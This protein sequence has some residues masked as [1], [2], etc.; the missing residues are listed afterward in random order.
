MPEGA[1]IGKITIIPRGQAGG[2]TRWQQEDKTY[3]TQEQLESQI[4]AAMG[5]RVAEVLKIGDVTTG[6]SNDFEQATN[7]AREMV[8]RLGMSDKLSNR[9]FGKRQGG[10]VFLG[11]EM[12]EE[13]DY[14]LKTEEII[15]SEINRILKEAE[16]NAKNILTKYDKELEKIANFLLKYET[17]ESDQFLAILEGKN[18][19]QKKQVKKESQSNS[20]N[21][22]KNINKQEDLPG[23]EPQT[24]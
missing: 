14:S 23:A 2:F 20:D 6:A 11:K 13:R 7:I 1:P 18:P 10:A 4:A 24:M 19:L 12:S 22:K 21:E 15:D 9:S 5:G 3:A 16:K 17:I 8:M